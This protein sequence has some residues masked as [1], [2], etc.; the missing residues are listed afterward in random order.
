[1]SYSIDSNVL[2][3]A[4]DESSPWCESAKE[5]L[6]WSASRSE[7]LCLCWPTLMAYLRIATHSKIF[8]NPLSPATARSNIE[9][10]IALPHSRLI[11]EGERFWGIYRSI[12]EQVVVRANLVP[13]VHLAALLVEHDVSVLYTRDRDFA[14]IDVVKTRDPFAAR[15]P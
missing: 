9:A 4:S 3:Y 6:S 1:M 5:F 12:T 8:T 2:L 7:P 10:L 14:K 13:D 11:T 15:E